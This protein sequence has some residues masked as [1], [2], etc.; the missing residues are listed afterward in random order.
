MTVAVDARLVDGEPG[1]VQQTILG[2]A[3]GLASLDDRGDRYEFLVH[4][5]HSWLE[6]ALTGPCRAL[7]VR[8]ER[9]MAGS[10]FRKAGR[11]LLESRGHIL[12]VSDGTA[13]ESGADLIHFMQQRGFRTRLPNIYQPHDL[14]HRHHPQ[15]FHPLQRAYRRLSYA[16]MSRQASRVAVM[17]TS[18]R[19][20]TAALLGVPLPR[21]IVVPWASVLSLYAEAPAPRAELDGLG[22]PARFLLFPSHSW[23]HKNHLGLLHALAAL[24]RSRGLRIPVVFT[25]SRTEHWKRVADAIRD[26]DLADQVISLGFVR[27]QVLK[28]LYAEADGLV[29]PTLYEGWGLPLVEA[30]DVGLP[31]ACSA[32]SPLR[33]IAMDAALLFDP[34]DPMDMAEAIRVIWTEPAE[35]DRLRTAALARRRAFSW[36]GTAAR[37]RAHYR[38]I[39]GLSPLDEDQRLLDSDAPV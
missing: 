22:V 1:G 34:T 39:L 38:D 4:P 14:Q 19:A 5:D 28:S 6:P 27:T 24:R 9:R 21:V 32:I 33:E 17:T 36:K 7:V 37:F 2:L 10:A 26:L 25:G 8:S 16:A 18:A 3:M 31:V 13:E 30:L 23:P 20:E 12:P 35:R 29:F 11:Y 15:L